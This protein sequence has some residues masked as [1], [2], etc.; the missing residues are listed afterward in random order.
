MGDFEQQKEQEE[1]QSLIAFSHGDPVPNSVFAVTLSQ[2]LE[3][4]ARQ[5]TGIVYHHLDNTSHW[6]SYGQLL[7]EAES[8]L[9]GLRQQGLQPQDKVILQLQNQQYF[10]TSLWACWLGGFIPVPLDAAHVY[11]QDRSNTKLFQVCQLCKPALIITES[12]LQNA[13]SK[14]RAER[15]AI[16]CD[17]CEIQNTLVITV[18]DLLEHSLSYQQDALHHHSQ[19]DDLALL[20]FTSGSTGVPKGVMLSARNLL[21]NTYGMATANNLNQQDITL[22]WMPLEHVASLVMFH[23]TEVYLGCQQIQVSSQ[24]ILQNPL[25]WLYLIDQYRV[26]ATWSPN[27]G[28]S[29]V[30]EQLEKEHKDKH[31]Y[32]WDLTSM[33]WMGNGAEA[34]V[35]QTTKRFLE[36]LAPYGL[37][38]SAVSP[39]YGMSETCSGITHSHC[40]G[41][42]THS[43]GLV[44]VG[45]PIPG[46]SLR[47]VN[48][49]NEVI[50]EGETGLL[51]VK[52]FTVFQGYYGRSQ[53]NQEVFTSDG[54]F[55]TGDLGFL[56]SGRL[57]ITGRQKDVIIINGVNYYNHDIEAVVEKIP[58]VMVSYTAACGVCDAH[59]ATGFAHRKQQEQLAIFLCLTDKTEDKLRELIKIIRKAVFTE[60]GVNPSYI[61][62]VV[63]ET[64]PKTAIGKIQRQQL[65]QRFQAGEFDS[66]VEYISQVLKNRDLGTQEVPGNA[67]EQSLVKIWQEILQL[68]IVSIKD[69]FFE[70]GGN[71]LLLMQILSELDQEFESQVSLTNLFQYP[72]IKTLAAYI[73]SYQS[74]QESLAVQQGI[75]RGELR[76]KANGSGAI[77]KATAQRAIAIIG[78]SCRFPG[79]ANLEQFWQ[80]LCDGVESIAFFKDEE[81]LAAGVDRQLLNNPNYVKASPILDQIEDFDADFWG[82]NAKEAR[83]LDPQ[84]RLFLE[85]AWESLEDA[86]CNPFDYDGEIALY[87]GAAINTYL[88]N[89]VY[90]NRHLLDESDPLEVVNLSSMGGFQATIANDK[91]YLTTRVSYKLNLTGSSVNV[92]TACSTSLV[93]VHLACQSIINGECD[94][95]IAGGVSIHTPQK[96]GYLYQEGM[97]LS[98][99]G[100]CRAFD[101]DAAG[102]IFGSG[103]GMVVLKDLERAVAE[104][105]RI[106][107]VIKGSA[108]N[109][110]G[111]TKVGYLAPNV[112][113]QARV[114]AEALA[115]ADVAPETIS[116]VEAHG[117]GTKLGDPIEIAA[118]TEAFNSKNK[119]RSGYCAIGSVKTNV[120]HL[121]IASGIVGLIKTALSLHHQK[122]PASLH[123][124]QP[125][126]QIDFTR[127]PFY[128]NTQLQDWKKDNYPRRAGVNSLGIGGTNSHLIL[129]ESPAIRNLDHNSDHKSQLHLLT[130][131]AKSEIALQE[132]QQSY[133]EFLMKHPETSLADICFT[134]NTGRV[135]LE[136]R[137]AIVTTNKEQ[138]QQ[139][140]DTQTSNCYQGK[141]NHTETLKI[142]WLFTGQGSQYEGMGYQ[143]Y[144]TQP[145]FQQAIDECAAIL[146]QYLDIPLLEV[147]YPNL[148]PQPSD[149]LNKT[150]YTQPALFALE[151]AIAK[152]WLSWGVKPNLVMGHS[153]GEYVAACIA[154]VFTLEAG[155]KLIA[156]RGKL[157]QSLPQDGTMVAVFASKA[158]I[159]S[160]ISLNISKVCFAADNGSY[161]VLSGLTAAVTEIVNQLEAEGIQT[162]FLPVSHAFHSP[163]MQ[164]IVEEFRQVADSIN[165]SPPQIPI[166]SNVTGE[167]A[168]ENIANVDYWVEH[169]LQ[170]VQFAQGIRLLESQ[171]VNIYLEIGTKNTLIAI[172]K[173]ILADTNQQSPLFLSSLNPGQQDTGQIFSS[174]AQL[175]VRGVTIDWS[176]FALNSNS[177]CRRVSLPTY[178]FQRQRYWFDLPSPQA[179][180][181]LV[182]Q[183]THPLLGEKIASPL[184]QI[185]FQSQLTS[186]NPYFLQDHCLETTPV[187]PGAAYLEMALAAGANQLK[188]TL[189]LQQVTIQQPLYLSDTPQT[190][191]LILS[192]EHEGATWEIYSHSSTKDSWQLHSEGKLVS[193]K[194]ISQTVE[195]NQLR[196]QFEN[197]AL[198]VQTHYQ[199]CQQRGI[200]YGANFQIIKQLWAISSEALGYIELPINL[201]ENNNYQLHPV[202][203][204]GCFQV[205]FATLPLELQSQ[206]YLPIGLD[207]LHLYDN[208]GSKLWSHVKLRN[209]QPDNAQIIIADLWLYSDRGD[210]ICHIQ[211]L[212]SQ[213]SNSQPIWHNWLYQ[214]QWKPQPLLN[215]SP[216]FTEPG[217]WLI[218]GDNSSLNQELITHLNSQQ[219]QCYL[220]TQEKNKDVLTTKEQDIIIPN[221]MGFARAER[222]ASEQPK[223]FEKL[224]QQVSQQ[225]LPLK[226]IIYL[227]NFDTPT[228]NSTVEIATEIATQG[229]RS[230]LYLIQ[231]LVKQNQSSP[232]WFITRNAQPVGSYQAAELDIAQSCLW[233]MGKAISLEHPELSPVYLDLDSNPSADEAQTIFKEICSRKTENQ[234]AFRDHQR[235][236]ARLERFRPSRRGERQ[237]ALTNAPTFQLQ[238]N[239]PGNLDNLQWEEITHPKRGYGEIKIQ[240]QATGLNFR[241]LMVAL[242]LYPGKEQFLG[243]E[244]TG[245]V[246]AVGESV[247]DFI[248]GD[249]VIAI[250]PN[251][252]SQYLNVNSLLAAHQPDNLSSEA[253][254]TIPVTFLT[255]YYTLVHLAQLQPGE[256]VLIHCAA[257]GVGL[258]AI[259]IAKQIG[260]EVWATASIPKWDLLKSMGVKQIMN[261]RTLDFAA[262]IGNKQID[263]VLNSLSGD[264]IPKSLSVLRDGGRFIE[265]GKQGIWSD[266]QVAEFNP[267]IIYFLVDLWQITQTQPALIQQMLGKL[268]PQF[269]AGKLKPLPY[270]I[271]TSDKI[272]DAFRY[273][274]QAKHQG[275][276]IVTQG[277]FDYRVRGRRRGELRFAPTE[278]SLDI[279]RDRIQYYRD[280]YLITGGLGAL[281]LQVAY[282]LVTQGIKHL[283]LMGRNDVKP[284]L[285]Q[286]LEQLQ[287]TGIKVVIAQGDVADT[288]QVAKVLSQ[289]ESTLPTL[290]GV[291]HAAGILDDGVLLQQDWVRFTRVL[292]PKV[293]GAWN[294]HLLTQKYDLDRFI[295]F[296]SASSLLGAAGQAN[297]CAANSFLDA[298]AHVRQ[299][300]GLPAIAINWGAWQ[301]IG[302]AAKAQIERSF[303]QKGIGTIHRKQ[304]ISILEQLL[305]HE[306]TQIG[307]IPI[308]WSQWSK[309]K[310]LTPFYQDLVPLTT[311]Q[312]RSATIRNLPQQLANVTYQ[313]RKSLLIQHISQQVAQILGINHIDTI[314]TQQ[315][316]SELGLDSLGSVEL[317]NKLQTS[318]EIRL[319]ATVIFDYPN[320]NAIANYLLATF[321]T[322]NSVENSST[323]EKNDL[324][325]LQELSEAEAEAL[326]IE[327]L[328]KLSI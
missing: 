287:Q 168:N 61:L 258:A 242:G 133:Q 8:I 67:I 28:Y 42:S 281:G 288:Q 29:L 197:K 26:T 232:I 6:Q 194:K 283:V 54:W 52:G 82:Y 315:G 46:V 76:R 289:I 78:M 196:Q 31:Q 188:T 41:K 124:N 183:A 260:A 259:A 237:F 123:F 291:I 49:E 98:P 65:I 129:E 311:A 241:D 325:Q 43:D 274:Q 122:L 143:L 59:S 70:L 304:A 193:E 317:R 14:A 185:I 244:C 214:Q 115:V 102:T 112:D 130:L 106:Y 235:Y 157:I 201:T 324:T 252:F 40:F 270:K 178:P 229:C 203:L 99:D 128:V 51:Q 246:V 264:F 7:T 81:M 121:Q 88:L 251:S 108:V 220:I 171:G 236:V 327:E 223:A 95:A 184:K 97:I 132:L 239:N 2:I 284:H 269:S 169:I 117:T 320:I 312:T 150:I 22:N 5:E 20:L 207:K 62:P 56:R 310:I 154:G 314:D 68:E 257:G 118:L 243:L 47:I 89:H 148:L 120:G 177:N 217:I 313:E 222:I 182:K 57:T 282:W 202:L 145:V 316:F 213:Q 209:I 189:S 107:A 295:L 186:S 318:L 135:H 212:Q 113:G 44:E 32:N 86:G 155:L 231:A 307:V 9:T 198:D 30:N 271:F 151:Y 63:P 303:A 138:L 319:S 187:F 23:L 276:I 200:N 119:S 21:A 227:W 254:A 13:M 279:D 262:Q 87:G 4:A 290:R 136:H 15:I 238:I 103:A 35:G 172:A 147:L 218:F 126:P 268:L 11:T 3:Q 204:D 50:Q 83:L 255:A 190:V 293:Q 116:Y 175:Y 110:D 275:K 92:Q 16:N 221:A 256:K 301:S 140:L 165:Y 38:P 250:A 170:P 305:L 141:I 179:I 300:Q 326:L 27:F 25:K 245:K 75:H 298:L 302:L 230:S 162:K 74:D 280:T 299:G 53:L 142:A 166:V 100:H 261:S 233:G 322:V 134:A 249:Q 192:P 73:S 45:A 91:D 94:L 109:N 158:Q 292:N 37:S 66:V 265:I 248:I 266:S 294:L 297:Y 176:T 69:N 12:P 36:L 191:Q 18:E 144:Q 156:A 64:M 286:Q 79:A 296:S 272:T 215:Q 161:L 174:L 263:V 308:E 225:Q 149:L 34:V 33:R 96:M 273:M 160:V 267:Q 71:S 85:C 323:Q 321:L 72:T 24:F 253:A 153:V 105:D 19:L 146:E 58:G 152:L 90:P 114:I 206:T 208:P 80:N 195:L 125:N 285:D 199:D 247:T 1:L 10:L 84:Q 216:S 60:I 181:P 77:G 210:L 159:E 127:S 328:K 205:L 309:N 173:Y 93:A 306:P 164:P 17:I 167:L 277:E 101:T 111:G 55:N 234:V 211:G 180:T 131:A 224:I 226:G 228:I 240:I 39:G 139:Q 104:G 48:P 219:Q 163:L 278:K 137:L